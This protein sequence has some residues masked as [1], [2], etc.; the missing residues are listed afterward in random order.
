MKIITKKKTQVIGQD[1]WCNTDADIIYCIIYPSD[2]GTANLLDTV[3]IILSVLLDKVAI[4]DCILNQTKCSLFI[5]FFTW[6]TTDKFFH[7][8]TNKI[9]QLNLSFF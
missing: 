5:N 8:N 6:P 2:S 9:M 7:L 1:I 3:Y 4:L